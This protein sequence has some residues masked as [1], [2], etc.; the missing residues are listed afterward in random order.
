M[1]SRLTKKRIITILI[2]LFTITLLTIG[3]IFHLSVYSDKI[4]IDY[5]H[6]SHFDQKEI[7][8]AVDCV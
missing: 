3:L 6:S 8:L 7:E 2:V 5:G 4:N 1:K